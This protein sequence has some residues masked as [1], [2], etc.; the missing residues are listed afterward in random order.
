MR[1]HQRQKDD[2][3][4][5]ALCHP[6][7]IRRK[8]KQSL[9]KNIRHQ[10]PPDLPW[11]K[12][13]FKNVAMQDLEGIS[14]VSIEQAVAAPY[15]SGRLAQAGARVIKVE[16]P[17]GDFARRYDSLVNGDSAYFVWL[18]H[19]KESIC[20][21]LKKDTEKALLHKIIAKADIFIQNLAPGAAQRL[22]FGATELRQQHPSLIYCSISGFGEHG[23][24][25]H[26]KAY[27]LLIQA[28][29]GLSL[30]HI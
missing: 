29:S 8:L 14:V 23:P 9:S 5:F 13:Q 11:L 1:I 16:R 12:A 22:G 7:K 10:Q 25:A 28:E 26:Q 2:G 6:T 18:N 20:V 19:G 3:C 15:A 4:G 30:I 27:D 21:D 24:Y 17:E